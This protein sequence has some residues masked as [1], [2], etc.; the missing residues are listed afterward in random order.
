M[1]SES[2]RT[3]G[4]I[5]DSFACSDLSS[6]LCVRFA[7]IICLLCK[8]CARKVGVSSKIMG[9]SVSMNLFMITRC[10]RGENDL[11]GSGIGCVTQVGLEFEC[12]LKH[13]AEWMANVA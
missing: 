12:L 13:S 9:L 7:A 6:S 3:S 11:G 10:S 1:I 4:S 5:L 2:I 8:G